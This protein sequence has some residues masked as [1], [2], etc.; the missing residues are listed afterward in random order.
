MHSTADIVCRGRTACD[1]TLFFVVLANTL[2]PLSKCN[3]TGESRVKFQPNTWC[4]EAV[5]HFW[6]I[7]CWK[8]ACN[9]LMHLLMDVHGAQENKEIHEILSTQ[10]DTTCTYVYGGC[11]SLL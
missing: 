3:M 10:C 11:T 5:M 2:P 7:Q 4:D 8:P 6:V 9:G 1:A